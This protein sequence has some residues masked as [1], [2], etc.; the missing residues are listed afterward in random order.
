MSD[1]KS[2]NNEKSPVNEEE[3][4][5]TSEKFNPLKALY[6]KDVKLPV[7]N[8]KQLDNLGIFLSRLKNAGN[9]FEAEVRIEKLELKYIKLIFFQLTQQKPSTSKATPVESKDT[10]ESER[11]HV[12]ATGRRFLKE[13]G[14]FNHDHNF[15]ILTFSI[16]QHQFIEEKGLSTKEIYLF[17]WKIQG[18][19]CVYFK[20]LGVKGQK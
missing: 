6:S 10:E 13:Q 16:I 9:N 15:I 20:N 4:D 17:E 19:H 11:Y 7:K 8:V 5:V 3:L 18:D 1:E 2:E 12:T 14:K